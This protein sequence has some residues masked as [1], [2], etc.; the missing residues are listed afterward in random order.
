[1]LDK[2]SN[3]IVMDYPWVTNFSNPQTQELCDVS[4]YG[5]T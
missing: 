3:N 5:T 1:M 4:P 2:V